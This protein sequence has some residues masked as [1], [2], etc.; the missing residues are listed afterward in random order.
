LGVFS[1]VRD[2][3]EHLGEL[4]RLHHRPLFISSDHLL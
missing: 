4:A 1:F 2:S 3:D